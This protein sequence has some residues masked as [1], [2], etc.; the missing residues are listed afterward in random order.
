[1]KCPFA[2]VPI[3]RPGILSACRVLLLVLVLSLAPSLPANWPAWRGGA[4]GGGQVPEA[5]L[6]VTWGPEKNVR[7]KV[8]L[9]ER[10]NSTPVIWNDRIFVTQAVE[11]DHRRTLMCFDRKD[12]RVLWQKGTTWEQEEPSHPT[13]PYCSSSPVTDGERVIAWFGSAGVFAYDFAGREL[14][15]RDLGEQSH[16]WGYGS[17]PLL[18]GE[19]CILYFGPGERQFLI[20][21]DKKTG[22]TVWKTEQPALG[23]RPRT[24]GFRGREQGGIIG[25]FSTPI[26]IETDGRRELVMSYPQLLCGYDPA[27]GREL[28]RADGLNELIYASPIAG[29]SVIVGMGGFLGTS[30]AIQAG[31]TGD[32][33]GK[34]EL[35]KSVRTKNRLGSGVIHD[36]HI[37]ILNSDGIAECLDLKTGREVWQERLPKEGPKGDSWSSMVLAG[38]LLYVLNQSADTVVLKASPDF[39]VVSV[40]PL[41]GALTNA[42]LAASRG[43]W[44]VRTHTHL[45]CIGAAE[46]QAKTVRPA[47][48]TG[49]KFAEGN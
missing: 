39:A 8:P 15:R 48:P 20:A 21:L 24:D 35:W 11:A 34:N 5:D 42:S 36:G 6:P 30:L 44:F 32:V 28:W 16:E 38:E 1:M 19:L 4:P 3:L 40:N 13:N 7:W 14:W 41:D 22:E 29:E 23:E 10:G 46:V 31:G 43:E 25:S 45:W 27:T 49:L 17:S 33:T 18:H 12:G 37:Y 2:T 47:P 26:L 9:P